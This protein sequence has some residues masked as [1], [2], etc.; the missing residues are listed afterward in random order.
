M[1]N[2]SLKILLTG[3]T[4]FLGSSVVKQIIK[5]GNT[6][7]VLLRQ[8]SNIT[9]LQEILG[10]SSVPYSYLLN[11]DTINEIRTYKPDALIH[12]GWRGVAGKERNEAYQVTDN[13]KLSLDTVELAHQ[14]GC[15]HWVGIGSQAEYGNPNRQVDEL[16]TTQPTTIYGRAKL[17]TCWA[18]LGLCQ[19]YNLQGSWMRVFSLYGEGD[20]PHWLIPYIIKEMSLG[21]S[22]KLT[23]CEQ[24]WDYLY[25][26][27]AARAILSVIYSNV[28]GIFNLG[29]GTAYPLKYIVENIRELVN[30]K[31]E[32]QYGAVEYRHDQVM[33]LQADMTK[34]SQMTNWN[35]QVSIEK[36][37]SKTVDWLTKSLLSY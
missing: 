10:Y 17:A 11:E 24:M 19:A 37:L 20:E 25:V 2:P 34:L 6:P 9:R 30:H 27:D 32:P 22:P 21:N 18:S 29:S 26:D 36:G 4:G 12:L 13:L 33:H 35:P 7:I 8:S 3:A 5:D 15:R 1:P 23:L 16:F 28:D 14:T 31:V